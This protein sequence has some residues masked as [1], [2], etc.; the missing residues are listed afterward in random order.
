MLVF[1]NTSPI[2]YDDFIQFSVDVNTRFTQI[3]TDNSNNTSNIEFL[4][5]S[6]ANLSNSLVVLS[7]TVI[8]MSNTIIDLTTKVNDLIIAS[9]NTA[10][11]NTIVIE[12]PGIYNSV[13]GDKIFF[14]VNNS[15][16]VLPSIPANGNFVTVGV[17]NFSNT[18]INRN[19]N[20]IMS[21]NEDLLIDVA[22][23][24]ISLIY[25]GSTIG[26]KIY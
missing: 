24:T 19:N 25:T 11:S 15:I 18:T 16:V 6:V 20:N 22:N 17:G 2:F 7:N 26:W 21:I 13:P 4:A 10:L 1:P 14:N 3:T 9:G 5:N 8:D 23:V 12:T